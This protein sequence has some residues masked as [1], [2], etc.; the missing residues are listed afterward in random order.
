MTKSITSFKN[1]RKRGVVLTTVGLKR[2]QT[3]IQAMELAENKGERW[4]LEQ[5]GDRINVSTRTLSRLWSLHTK[6]DQKTLKLCFSAFNLELSDEDYT[7]FRE[8]HLSKEVEQ[9]SLSHESTK[10]TYLDAYPDGPVPLD[11]PLYIE[12][13]PIE[14]LAYQEIV[15]PG[16]LIRI[17]A[18]KEMGK[19]S[20]VLRLLTFARNQQYQT[21]VFN[22]NQI[23]LFYLSDLNKLLRCLGKQIA[24]Q[25]DLKLN[26]DD[27]WDEEIGSKLSCSLM[28]HQILKNRENPIVLV[29]NEVERIFEQSDLA[30]D[31]FSLLRSWYEDARQ[32]TDWQKLRLVVVYSTE[33]YIN[34]DINR[35]PFNVGLPLHLGELTSQQVT[36]LALRH[37]LNWKTNQTEQLM[38]LVGGHP[39]LIRI[40]LYYINTQGITLKDLIKEAL[41]DGGIY[42]YHLWRHWLTLQKHASLVNT[43]TDILTTNQSFY[44]NSI[45][46]YK[47]ESIGL[48]CYDGDQIRLRCELYHSYFMKQLL[49]LNLGLD[50]KSKSLT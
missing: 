31:F 22:F 30:Q 25:L 19:S 38:T 42:R 37:G 26:L 10:S 6:V 13:P 14:E 5:L 1:S 36:E 12:R 33:E 48:I 20:L 28:V 21:I 11:S 27:Y 44:F 49:L 50:E 9:N 46:A 7:I 29:L 15:Y 39:A 2:L 40:A 16:C 35:S 24:N 43:L 41:T 3:A 18:P 34:L 17:R 45:Q 32:D 23:D 4:T 8:S 47:L